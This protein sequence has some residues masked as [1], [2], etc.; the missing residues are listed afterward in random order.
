MS[1]FYNG[2][3]MYL[4]RK[5]T[6]FTLLF[7]TTWLISA[8]PFSVS[9]ECSCCINQE[10]KCGC[11]ENNHLQ[12]SFFQNHSSGKYT[13]CIECNGIPAKEF[14]WVNGCSL[15]LEQKQLLSL[16]HYV[17]AKPASLSLEGTSTSL[18]TPYPVSSPPLFL[19]NSTLLL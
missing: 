3:K 6:L 5:K 18:R 16:P 13:P 17:L 12:K 19:I 7:L 10:C 9:A 2:G 15:Q 8:F 14:F 11:T 1:V 4:L